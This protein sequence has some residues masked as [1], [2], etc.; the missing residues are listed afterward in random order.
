MQK[1]KKMK[2]LTT[3][4][5]ICTMGILSACNAQTE[6]KLET[7]KQKEQTIKVDSGKPMNLIDEQMKQ[8]ASIFSTIET[9]DEINP[10]SGSNNY[11]EVVDKMDAPEE[12]KQ[13]IREQYK[14]YDLSLD[15]KK[16][17]S[18]ELMVNKML[19]GA[20]AKSQSD[21]NK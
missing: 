11:L 7:S 9:D 13:M 16:K 15:P 17:D 20:I 21:S 19:E 12:M 3:I 2:S 8:L 14:I 4:L 10:F 1:L 18:L 6:K 5:I